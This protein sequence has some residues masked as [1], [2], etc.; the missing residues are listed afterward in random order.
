MTFGTLLVLLLAPLALSSIIQGP[1]GEV[2]LCGGGSC[3]NI[4]ITA[5][6]R[7]STLSTLKLITPPSDTDASVSLDI[8]DIPRTSDYYVKAT[9]VDQQETLQFPLNGASDTLDIALDTERLCNIQLCTVYDLDEFCGPS[10]LSSPVESEQTTAFK[11]HGNITRVSYKDAFTW[12]V[13]GWT[14]EVIFT[15][16]DTAESYNG[17]PLIH[18]F[19]AGSPTNKH[20]FIPRRIQETHLQ[21]YTA[22]G[23]SHSVADVFPIFNQTY[24][25]FITMDTDRTSQAF[26]DGVSFPITFPG[27]SFQQ[28]LVSV[29]SGAFFDSAVDELSMSH[30]LAGEASVTY[31]RIYN[32]V[33]TVGEMT[34]L[35]STGP[36]VK[37]S[38]SLRQNLL[39]DFNVGRGV[40]NG[41]AVGE[42]A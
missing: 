34:T 22:P 18:F 25:V 41:S 27:D 23:I 21:I 24:H 38:A 4:P 8:T 31:T 17:F 30:L 19:S 26:V 7:L 29:C 33:L 42:L 9:F 6:E 16:S 11:A 32:R 5:T 36:T 13:P 1:N 15:S 12:P 10:L 2:D 20:F 40:G 35:Q 37:P 39:F 28:E 3:P 14:V